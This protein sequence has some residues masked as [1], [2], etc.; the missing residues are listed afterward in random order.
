MKGKNISFLDYERIP[1]TQFLNFF[2]NEAEW[3]S[4]I[5]NTE[6]PLMKLLRIDNLFMIK[7]LIPA[8]SVTSP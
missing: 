3:N 4:L 5:E 6:S 2:R 7:H 1:Y 8:K